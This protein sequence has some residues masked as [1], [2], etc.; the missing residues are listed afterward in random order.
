MIMS[1]DKSL[2]K[3]LRR[4]KNHGR[5]TKGT[6]WHETV[7]FNFCTSDLHSALGYSQLVR[8]DAIRKR[9]L[10]IFQK[11]EVELQSTDIKLDKITSKNPAYW[12]V[13]IWHDEVENLADYLKSK[14]IQTRRAFPP[15]ASQPCYIDNTNIVFKSYETATQIYNKYLSLPSS[16]S[17]TDLDIKRVCDELRKF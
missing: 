14:G 15:L 1:N 5:E 12:F 10:E 4:L 8:F 7:G 3:D 13:S 16:F 17:L 11:Y 9:K 2:M 6:F